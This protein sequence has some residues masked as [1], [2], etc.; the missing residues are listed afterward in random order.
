MTDATSDDTD[1][2]RALPWNTGPSSGLGSQS[3]DWCGRNIYAPAL[4]CS[5]EQI[6]DI[7]HLVVAPGL[8]DRC[9]WEMRVRGHLSRR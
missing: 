5:T 1:P 2:A 4:P 7:E 9:L 8:G 3:C 6:A